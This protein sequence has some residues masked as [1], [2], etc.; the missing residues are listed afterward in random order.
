MEIAFFSR[1][2]EKQSEDTKSIVRNLTQTGQLEFANAGWVMA[3]EATTTY[4]SVVNEM[5]LGHDYIER[6][7]GVRPK[8]GWHIGM[9]I[10]LLSSRCVVGTKARVPLH[11]PA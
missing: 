7:L 5:S 4:E 9:R 8:I 10:E 3:D 1:W 2:W 11:P 6:E